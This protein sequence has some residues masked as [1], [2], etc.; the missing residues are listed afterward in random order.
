[1]A[2]RGG[3]DLGGTKIQAVVVDDDHEVRGQSRSQT[4]LT[5][6]PGDIAAAMA[7][8]LRDSAGQAG[9]TPADLVGVGV[10]SP[11]QVDDATGVVSSAKNLPGWTGS[12]PL[13]PAPRGAL[14]GPA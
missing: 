6:G 1:M 3:I 10:G 5:G 8:G 7:R 9:T 13:P 14:R 12:L 11:G 4:P 2:L